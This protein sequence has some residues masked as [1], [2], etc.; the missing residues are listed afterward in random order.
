MLILSKRIKNKKKIKLFCSL[1][2]FIQLK[3]LHKIKSKRQMSQ[4]LSN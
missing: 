1:T 3:K 2:R 4:P